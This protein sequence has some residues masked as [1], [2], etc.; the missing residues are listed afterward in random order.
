M[1]DMPPAFLEPTNNGWEIIEWR[2]KSN[3]ST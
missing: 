1:Y 3:P 2:E